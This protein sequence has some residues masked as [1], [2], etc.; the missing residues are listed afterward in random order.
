MMVYGVLRGDCHHNFTT[1][2][3]TLREFKIPRA[4]EAGAFGSHHVS[5]CDCEA[6]FSGSSANGMITVPDKQCFGWAVKDSLPMSIARV[7]HPQAISSESS[8]SM[9]HR[10]EISQSTVLYALY[11]DNKY[12]AGPKYD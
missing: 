5:G 12:P 4:M 2:N 7:H 6:D 8:Q 3:Q 1:P 9:V 10:K 11:T